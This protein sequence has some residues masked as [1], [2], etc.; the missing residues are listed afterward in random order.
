[1][2]PHYIM[3]SGNGDDNFLPYQEGHHTIKLWQI[4]FGFCA[5]LV[6]HGNYNFYVIWLLNKWE[7]VL[8][9]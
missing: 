5:L 3:S 4:S 1:M 8:S 9:I 7:T 2:F 6:P